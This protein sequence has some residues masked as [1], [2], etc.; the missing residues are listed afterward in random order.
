MSENTVCGKEGCKPEDCENCSV[1]WAR[2]ARDR[3]D[4]EA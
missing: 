3:F 2:Q 1:Y 4:E